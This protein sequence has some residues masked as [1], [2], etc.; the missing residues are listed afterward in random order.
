MEWLV[1]AK[2]MPPILCLEIIRVMCYPTTN[3]MFSSTALWQP[4]RSEVCIPLFIIQIYSRHYFVFAAKKLNFGV[5][6]WRLTN[7][8]FLTSFGHVFWGR[9]VCLV[10]FL[11]PLKISIFSQL[12]I[13]CWLEL[14]TSSRLRPMR[15][16]NFKKSILW[17]LG[18]DFSQC[19]G[20]GS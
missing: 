3:S 9:G 6:K 2:Q 7:W 1:K 10:T 4:W 20:R 12:I 5:S 11:W 15:Q 17:I 14:D 18:T 8:F 13:Y 16:P 19:G